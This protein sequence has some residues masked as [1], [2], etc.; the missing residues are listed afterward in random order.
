MYTYKQFFDVFQELAFKIA[1]EALQKH[2]A[3]SMKADTS[4]NEFY[5]LDIGAYSITFNSSRISYY[6]KTGS[7]S[8]V[9]FQVEPKLYTD[10]PHSS[11]IHYDIYC[12]YPEPSAKV[13]AEKRK[14]YEKK[15]MAVVDELMKGVK[16]IPRFS[17]E[18]RA[19]KYAEARVMN[20]Q[21]KA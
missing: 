18:K 10:S 21:P 9:D 7:G 5:Q 15:I 17:L 11:K 13:K 16:P 8:D 2:Q 19:Q 12:G 4:V 3:I 14:A 6:Q 1:L 20:V